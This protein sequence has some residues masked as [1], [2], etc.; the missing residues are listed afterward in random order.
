MHDYRIVCPSYSMYDPNKSEICEA[1]KGNKYYNPILRK[2][3]K[4]SILI[5]FNIALESYIYYLLKTY[6]RNIDLFISPSRF[7]MKKVIEFGVKKEKIVHLPN[8]LKPNDYKPNYCNSHFF[9]FFGRIERHKGVKTLIDSMKQI[10]NLKLIIT[11]EGSDH[12]FLKEYVYKNKIKNVKFLGFIT[13]KKLIEL[14]K[15]SLFTVIPSE[16]YE[17][18]GMTILESF[19]LGKPV[20]G[21]KIGGIQEIIENQ[22]TGMLFESG[23]V[24]DLA[25]KINF[26]SSNRQFVIEMGKNAR[27]IV[28]KKYNEN[29][30]YENLMKTYHRLV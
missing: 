23:N 4:S 13:R 5:G 24:D 29:I 19:A 22:K 1:C 18:F 9:L 16:W 30:H 12:N 6:Q 8:F 7:L 11:G 17:P 2:C 26:L 14:I 20:I 3:Q 15:L 25:D 28:E 10:K 27:E 21:A